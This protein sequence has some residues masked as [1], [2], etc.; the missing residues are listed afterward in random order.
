MDN[1]NIGGL[2]VIPEENEQEVKHRIDEV[3]KKL[4]PYFI[5]PCRVLIDAAPNFNIEIVVD[6]SYDS[7]VK[8]GDNKRVTFSINEYYKNHQ[9]KSYHS[10]PKGRHNV[11]NTMY[12][13]ISKNG[14]YEPMQEAKQVLDIIKTKSAG[15]SQNEGNE[16]V[17]MYTPEFEG[18]PEDCKLSALPVK[19][20]AQPGPKMIESP[21]ASSGVV[22]NANLKLVT[23]AFSKPAKPKK[24]PKIYDGIFATY[25]GKQIGKK[26]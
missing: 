22:V 25:F 13:M 12:R 23:V 10:T 17:Y 2:K 5:E 4:A 24:T 18:N 26:R 19:Q 14:S 7:K 11:Y 21:K 15:K 6:V 16:G 20:T 9:V 1:Y 3:L 8:T